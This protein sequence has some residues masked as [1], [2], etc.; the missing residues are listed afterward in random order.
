M[1]VN[2]IDMKPNIAYSFV[3]PLLN[4]QIKRKAGEFQAVFIPNPLDLSMFA[5]SP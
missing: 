3:T 4:C 2:R 1:I 5:K